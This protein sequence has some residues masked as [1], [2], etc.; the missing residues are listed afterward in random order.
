MQQVVCAM[1]Q[2]GLSGMG[3]TPA[4]VARAS[5]SKAQL[6]ELERR[7]NLVAARRAEQDLVRVTRIRPDR[8]SLVGDVADPERQPGLIDACEPPISTG[9]APALATTC[10]TFGGVFPEKVSVEKSCRRAPSQELAFP[11]A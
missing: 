11:V 1:R 5:Q 9:D 3:K 10:G 2:F 6:S 4:E 8:I 7:R